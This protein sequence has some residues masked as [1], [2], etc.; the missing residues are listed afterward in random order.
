MVN[1]KKNNFENQLWEADSA[2]ELAKGLAE[3]LSDQIDMVVSP[4]TNL[5]DYNHMTDD[6]QS[7]VAYSVLNRKQALSTLIY[8]VLNKLDEAHEKL[9]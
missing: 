7:E 9:Q 1:N 3:A 5:G 2:V 6:Q 8:E 4:I